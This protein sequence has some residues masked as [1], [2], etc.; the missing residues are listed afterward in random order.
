MRLRDSV[1]GKRV[2]HFTRFTVVCA[3]SEKKK[4]TKEYY[5]KQEF[6]LKN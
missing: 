2:R 1:L 5:N 3:N 6:F 4:I